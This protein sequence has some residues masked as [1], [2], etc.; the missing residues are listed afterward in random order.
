MS[1]W[2]LSAV[3]VK[4]LIKPVQYAGH[5][6]PFPFPLD[7]RIVP[8][9][10]EHGIEGKRNKERYE[11]RKGDRH[12]ELEEEPPTIPF[13]NATGTKTATMEKVVA[14]TARPISLV[15]SLA[16]VKWSWPSSR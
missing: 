7:V 3:S 6:V 11:H 8:A 5:S 4:P 13:M 1:R 15:A 2:Y 9:G 10:R 16:A 12:A 14:I